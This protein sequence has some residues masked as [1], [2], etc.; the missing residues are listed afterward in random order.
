MDSYKTS[1]AWHFGHRL[2]Y[3]V[4]QLAK[5]LPESDVFGLAE[6]LRRVSVIAPTKIAESVNYKLHE[7]KV[8]CYLAAREATNQLQVHLSLA[9]DLRYIEQELYEELSERAIVAYKLLSAVIRS[10]TNA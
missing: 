3:D 1:K 5:N 2:A 8:S 9:R 7:D 6:A 4:H 10:T